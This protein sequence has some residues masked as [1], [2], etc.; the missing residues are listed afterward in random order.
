MTD[1]VKV[2]EHAL[3]VLF[4][5]IDMLLRREA[6]RSLF[7]MFLLL[8]FGLALLSTDCF[9]C[10]RGLL[11]RFMLYDIFVSRL[12]LLRFQVVVPQIESE[13]DEAIENHKRHP[14]ILNDQRV[15]GS[16]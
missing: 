5:L 8:I 2:K 11:F 10:S 15:D 6:Y 13:N 9:V 16:V 1:R 4:W 14:S 7:G 3:H 12:L